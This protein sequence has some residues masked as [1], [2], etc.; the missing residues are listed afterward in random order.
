MWKQA[1]VGAGS[2][3][4]LLGCAAVLLTVTAATAEPKAVLILSSLHDLDYAEAA[5]SH[6]RSVADIKDLARVLN[7]ASDYDPE[8]VKI[9]K[10][11]FD[12]ISECKSVNDPRELGRRLENNIMDQLAVN[13]QCAGVSAYIE[14]YDQ[15]DGEFNAVAMQAEERNDYW[16]L[17]V[18]YAP[19]SKVYSWAL[20]PTARGGRPNGR[21][22]SGEGTV[23]QI[24]EQVCIIVT[25]QG[26]S[27][28]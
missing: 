20:F 18:D 8:D 10:Q 7:N 4:V 3:L 25:G 9:N 27:V 14:G 24:A 22:V 1:G 5:C 28:R 11:L 23:S 21:M 17:M 15:F 2:L 16:G 12:G 26:A 13:R 19:E 6:L